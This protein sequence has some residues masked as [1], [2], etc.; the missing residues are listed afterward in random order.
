MCLGDWSVLGLVNDSDVTAIT[1]LPDVDGDGEDD[2]ELEGGW[3]AI[4]S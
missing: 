1:V 3:D 2:M 4:V